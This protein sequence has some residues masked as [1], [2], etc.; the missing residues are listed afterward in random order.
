MGT[1]KETHRGSRAI[2]QPK[3]HTWETLG[4]KHHC[5]VLTEIPLGKRNTP[6]LKPMSGKAKNRAP[7]E[8]GTAIPKQHHAEEEDGETP[9]GGWEKGEAWCKEPTGAGSR[10]SNSELGAHSQQGA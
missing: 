2:P 10:Q 6:K 7:P 5:E 8:G 9:Q 3:E 1:A 4:A